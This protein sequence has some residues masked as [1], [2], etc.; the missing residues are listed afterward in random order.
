MQYI[1]AMTDGKSIVDD[2]ISKLN[3]NTIYQIQKLWKNV[4]DLELY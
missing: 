1:Y 2:D 3:K 4:I